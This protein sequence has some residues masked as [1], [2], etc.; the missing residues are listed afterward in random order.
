MA[1]RASSDSGD[2]LPLRVGLG[3][4]FRTPALWGT[5]ERASEPTFPTFESPGKKETAG[6]EGRC[7]VGRGLSGFHG[8]GRSAGVKV[9]QDDFEIFPR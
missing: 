9:T 7:L 2:C 6:M 4:G 8:P 3:E 1:H 5:V